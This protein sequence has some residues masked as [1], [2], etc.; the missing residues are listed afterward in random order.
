MRGVGLRRGGEFVTEKV[1]PI[2]LFAKLISAISENSG[3]RRVVLENF[4]KLSSRFQ[5]S[6]EQLQ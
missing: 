6:Y 1:Q 5:D 2:S 4:G 3:D